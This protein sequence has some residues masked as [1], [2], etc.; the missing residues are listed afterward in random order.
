M[1]KNSSD[2]NSTSEGISPEVVAV[3]AR[4]K[5]SFIFSIG[6]LIVGLLSIALVLIFKS[7]ERGNNLEAK[8]DIK[9][10]YSV[11][12]LVVP[13]GAQIVSAVPNE[14]M[15][16]I[17]YI[18]NGKTTLRLIDGTTGAIIRDISFVKE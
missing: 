1:S 17:T 18:K 4:A 7:D 3:I 10:K 6:L 5:R 11:G 15:V 13:D 12:M 16:A 2:D 9:D 8:N 14:G